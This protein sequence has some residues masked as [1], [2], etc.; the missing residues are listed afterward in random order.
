[1]DSIQVTLFDPRYDAPVE[2]SWKGFI[3]PKNPAG[4][5]SLHAK[6]WGFS[7]DY[8][9]QERDGW[10]CTIKTDDFSAYLQILPTITPFTKYDNKFSHEYTLLHFFR[11]RVQGQIKVDGRDIH[12]QDALGYYDHCFGTVPTRSKWHWIA[13]QNEGFSLSSLMNYGP[14]AQCYTQCFDSQKRWI[15]LDQDVS[16]ECDPEYQWTKPW[17]ITSPDMDLELVVLQRSQNRQKIPPLLPFIINIDH[18]ECYVRVR[19]TVRIDG[20]W[21]DT[22]DLFGVLEEHHGKW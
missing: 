1:M 17:K 8:T 18:S 14:F 6:G 15:R 16:F 3:N 22:G 9:G 20:N 13:V 12:L 5:L 2:R 19:G 4:Q 11:N 7:F 10:S 21:V